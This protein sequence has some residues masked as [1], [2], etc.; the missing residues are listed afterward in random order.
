VPDRLRTEP[1]YWSKDPPY[2]HNTHFH[3]SQLL[4]IEKCDALV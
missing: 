3:G 1:L 4:H 2:Q